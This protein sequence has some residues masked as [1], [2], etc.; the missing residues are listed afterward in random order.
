MARPKKINKEELQVKIN[1]IRD[2][3]GLLLNGVDYKFNKYGMVDWRT[4][5]P[6]EYVVLN[7]YVIG[8]KKGI[9]VSTL[10]EAEYQELLSKAT[11]DEKLIKLQ[12]FKDLALIRGYSNLESNLLERNEDRAVVKVSITWEPNLESPYPKTVTAIKNASVSNTD[13]NF[14]KYLEA[15]AENR[16]FVTVVRNSLNIPIIGYDE[17][18]NTEKLELG[19]TIAGSPQFFL[20]KECNSNGISFEALAAKALSRGYSWS[21]SWNTFSDLD[22]P[23]AASCLHDLKTN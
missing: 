8:R 10:N 3:N 11:E 4:L 19:Q 6:Q 20:E 13:P 17:I 2:E 18:D 1:S 14:I 12:G 5:I 9:D 16:A 7:R 22:A 21:E 23:T 15:I